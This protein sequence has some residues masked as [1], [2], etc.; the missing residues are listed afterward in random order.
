LTLPPRPYQS[1]RYRNIAIE[2]HVS[3]IV[4]KAT[5]LE[6]ARAG[7]DRKEENGTSEI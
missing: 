7:K 1:K 5:L 6:I 2:R 3:T 4:R